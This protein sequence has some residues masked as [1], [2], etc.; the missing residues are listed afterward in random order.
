MEN[1]EYKGTPLGKNAAT[2]GDVVIQGLY[3]D[4]TNGKSYMKRS[5]TQNLVEFNGDNALSLMEVAGK[6]IGIS[7]A[8]INYAL[9]K[10][11]M[12]RD[13][14]GRL[15][16]N[17]DPKLEQ[18]REQR[19]QVAQAQAQ[20]VSQKTTQLDS[21]IDKKDINAINNDI[22]KD[23]TIEVPDKGV[24]K[25]P[26]VK[27]TTGW[28][29]WATGA[30]FDLYDGDEKVKSDLTIEEMKELIPSIRAKSYNVAAPKQEPKKST[31]P[32]KPVVLEKGALDDL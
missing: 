8:N 6:R 4:P 32:A 10:N 14:Q 27:K 2:G 17:A 11:N 5:D 22:F 12:V 20:L 18:E 3:Y 13:E 25:N 7:D 24:L 31:T 15:Q 26:K 28:F 29:D 21:A 1:L 9:R 19:R 16:F 30:T 23:V